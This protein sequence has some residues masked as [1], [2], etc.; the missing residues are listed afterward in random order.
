[1]LSTA[2]F[3][4]QS[5]QAQEPAC[6][7][8]APA[9]ARETA[10]ILQ[11]AST[12]DWLPR[13]LPLTADDESR[14]V[15]RLRPLIEKIARSYRCRRESTEDMVQAVFLR[16][17]KNFHQYSGTVPLV[18]WVARIAVN[19]CLN[20]INMEK[21]RPELRCADLSEND[22]EQLAH[23]HST[24]SCASEEGS[25]ADGLAS[26]ESVTILLARLSEDDRRILYL[27]HVENQSVAAVSKLTG[28]S[29]AAVKLRAMRARR[30]LQKQL[31]Q[32]RAF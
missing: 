27:R 19:T 13:A 1:M 10:S 14:F 9:G 5:R 32:S 20:Q 23:I 8:L 16:V 30:N 12:D 24:D 25:P 2:A 29:A 31:N 15:Q 26:R 28:F 18:H 21:R 7:V 17:W 22:L 4:S 6:P 11:P 3:E